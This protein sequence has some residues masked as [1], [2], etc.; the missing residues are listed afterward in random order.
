MDLTPFPPPAPAGPFK[1]VKPTLHV[2]QWDGTKEDALA[3]TG[4]LSAILLGLDS[5]IL[6][7]HRRIDTRDHGGFRIEF[8]VIRNQDEETFNFSVYPHNWVV[9]WEGMSI[10]Q[11]IEV[12]GARTGDSR[13][14][15][16]VLTL[17]E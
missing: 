8:A 16:P 12:V 10:L 2:A 15:A 11:D 9:V 1:V 6:G 4:A 17:R 5:Q 3:L 14:V 7:A 13:F